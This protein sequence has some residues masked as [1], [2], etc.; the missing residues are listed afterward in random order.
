MKSA[1]E[2]RVDLEEERTRQT[3]EALAEVD[4][5]KTLAHKDVQAWAQ[6]LGTAHPLPLPIAREKLK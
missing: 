6:S 1:Q 4:A 5:G 3:L 2:L